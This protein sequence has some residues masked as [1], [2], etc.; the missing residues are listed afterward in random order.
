MSLLLVNQNPEGQKPLVALDI[1]TTGSDANTDRI[2]E[3]AMIKQVGG[4]RT[5]W[6]KRFNPGIAIHPAASAVHGITDEQVRELEPFDAFKTEVV[7]FLRDS[8][9]IGYNLIHFDLPVL[10]REMGPDCKVI[11]KSR[12]IDLMQLYFHVAPRT[13]SAACKQYLGRD[14]EDAHQALADT[15]CVLDL[16]PA[17]VTAEA[18]KLPQTMEGLADLT[19]E[20]WTARTLAKNP[21]GSMEFRIGKHRGKRV[22]D[23]AR[24]D[25]D[26]LRWF[27]RQECSPK[28][29]DI[30]LKAILSAMEKRSGN[31]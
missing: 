6:V 13:L 28:A 2:V 8:D 12:V 21:D 14:L 4:Q 17:M 10:R 5:E 24:I 22:D 9:L 25:L 3:L 27:S 15:A 20:L 18:N 7:E 26:Y 30:F 23:V 29:K 1:E 16:L 11:E 31:H 19:D